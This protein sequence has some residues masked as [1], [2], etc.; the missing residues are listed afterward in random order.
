MNDSSAIKYP[1][2]VFALLV[3]GQALAPLAAATPN[4][5]NHDES[6]VGNYTLPD[7]LLAK[8]GTRVTE[9]AGWRSRR[10]GKILRSFAAHM[11]G[12]TPA[13]AAE[14]ARRGDV[15]PGRRGRRPRHADARHVAVLR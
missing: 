13:A 9:A 12:V 10:R 7:A 2:I 5:F 3:A 6:K 11:Y 15:D 8:D 4:R 14:G 1:F